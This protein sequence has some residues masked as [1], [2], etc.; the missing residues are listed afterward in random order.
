MIWIPGKPVPFQRTGTSRTG[1][2]FSIPVYREWK[3]M[4]GWEIQAQT[5]DR[6]RG[7]IALELV[8]SVDGMAVIGREVA[9]D[10]RPIKRGL[11]GDIDNYGKAFLDAAN[12]ILFADDR[13]VVDLSVR[14]PYETEPPE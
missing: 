5:S 2:R 13:Q 4:A 12:G 1:H 10:H 8:V 14:F 7:A 9:D 3:E 11:R 6:L